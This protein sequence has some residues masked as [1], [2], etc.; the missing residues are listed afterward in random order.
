MKYE[1]YN[2]KFMYAFKCIN[3]PKLNSCSS[4]SMKVIKLT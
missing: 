1:N 4:S 2:A 3:I